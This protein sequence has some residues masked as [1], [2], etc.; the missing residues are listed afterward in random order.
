MDILNEDLWCGGLMGLDWME[1]IKL[2]CFM[3]NKKKPFPSW[4]T[5]AVVIPA[6]GR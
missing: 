3:R 6:Y 1:E 2:M 5:G 4:T